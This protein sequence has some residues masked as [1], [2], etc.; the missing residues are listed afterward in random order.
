[1]RKPKAPK[2]V[3]I[4]ILTTITVLAWV[5][6]ETYRALTSQPDVNVPEEILEPLNPNLDTATLDKINQRVYFEESK[7][8]EL[9]VQPTP[10]P[11]ATPSGQEEATQSAGT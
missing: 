7:I 2:L 1:M 6:F 10:T 11:V 8:I 9:L 5:F 3:H 4:A